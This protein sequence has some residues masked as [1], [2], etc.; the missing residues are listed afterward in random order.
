MSKPK[1]HLDADRLDSVTL[2]PPPPPEG[3]IEFK[4]L[5]AEVRPNYI[6]C[7]QDLQAPPDCPH[8]DHLVDY[9]HDL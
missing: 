6:I 2:L 7:L 9:V 8:L 5:D 4:L 3:S 1:G